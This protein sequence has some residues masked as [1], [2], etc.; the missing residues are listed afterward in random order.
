[1]SEREHP[2]PV[3]RARLTRGWATVAS[4][5]RCTSHSTFVATR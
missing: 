2:Q 3:R 5:S 1:M 4:A